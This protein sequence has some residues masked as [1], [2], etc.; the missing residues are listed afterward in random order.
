MTLIMIMSVIWL[1]R[2][3]STNWQTHS[4]IL[5]CLPRVYCYVKARDQTCWNHN[6]DRFPNNMPVEPM[7]FSPHVFRLCRQSFATHW[8][9]SS[10][11]MSLWRSGRRQTR[12][13][14]IVSFGCTLDGGEKEGPLEHPNTCGFALRNFKMDLQCLVALGIRTTQDAR[15]MAIALAA[16]HW[17][18]KFD[19]RD[20]E[21]DLGRRPA[22]TH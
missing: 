4:P 22:G 17:H 19:A 5:P 8:S 7:C 14:T 3:A 9:T 12:R 11:S 21:F 13:T 6:L 18:S 16:M 2:P 15:S 1:S 10:A 20:V